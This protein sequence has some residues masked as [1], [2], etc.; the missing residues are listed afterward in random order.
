MISD[1]RS[2]APE[3]GSQHEAAPGEAVGER[4]EQRPTEEGGKKGDRKARSG[5]QWRAALIEHQ[6]GQRHARDLVACLAG[7]LREHHAAEFAHGQDVAQ[8][9][10]V[11]VQLAS[12]SAIVCHA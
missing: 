7:H 6:Q 3:V 4:S 8:L 11:P 1:C 5:Q 10:R 12:S 9:H 2:P